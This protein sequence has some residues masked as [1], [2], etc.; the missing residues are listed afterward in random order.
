VLNAC[1]VEGPTLLLHEDNNFL[2][3]PDLVLNAA[4][5][6][7]AD[8]VLLA[9]PHSPSGS[10]AQVSILT[11]LRQTL[12]RLGIAIILDEA[13]IDF[14]PESGVSESAVHSTDLIVLRSLTKFFAIPGMRVAYAV[15]HPELRAR[16]ES[17]LPLWPVDSLAASA[18]QLAVLD[19]ICVRERREANT[20]ERQWLSEQLAS[21]G[22]QVFPGRANYLLIKPPGQVDG[23]K[24]WR[25]LIIEDGI[26]LRNCGTFEGLTTAHFRVAVRDRPTNTRLVNTLA[27][28]FAGRVRSLDNSFRKHDVH[29]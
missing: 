3:D 9:N 26:V 18:A 24:I 6:S 7:R 20:R 23:L 4:V 11:E 27:R 19:G 1:G 25:Q 8:V 21:L 17:M 12:S 5:A 2:L 16:M 10:L 22:W 28:L 29:S 14:C 15:V 13:F